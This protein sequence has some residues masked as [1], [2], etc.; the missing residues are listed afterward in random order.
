VQGSKK[1]AVRIGV[2]TLDTQIIPTG[3]TTMQ[4]LLFRFLSIVFILCTA[5]F[6]CV[7]LL[8]IA[9]AFSW[10]Y[11]T[12]FN[13]TYAII[14]FGLSVPSSYAWILVSRKLN[15]QQ[16]QSNPENK[17]QT[18]FT[19]TKKYFLI[20]CQIL[21]SVLAVLCMVSCVCGFFFIQYGIAPILFILFSFAFLIGSIVVFERLRKRLKNY[22]GD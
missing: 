4:K 19:K 13:M 5:S 12:Q 21:V 6:V 18:T 1:S 8:E 2:N 9:F 17:N 11:S 14:S 10:E 22:N 3:L 20:V 15:S 16:I 7:F